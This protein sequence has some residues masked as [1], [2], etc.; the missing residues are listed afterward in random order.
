[1]CAETIE[2]D[3]EICLVPCEGI[4][5]DAKKQPFDNLDAEKDKM[6]IERYKNYKTYGAYY[7]AYGASGACTH[8]QHFFLL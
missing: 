3:T 6:L 4:F 7:Q 5:A 2:I 1:M 8:L